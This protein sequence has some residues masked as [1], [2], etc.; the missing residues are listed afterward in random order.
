MRR[1]IFLLALLCAGAAA[2]LEPMPFKDAEEEARF[3]AL[4]AELRCVM[5]QNQSLADSNAMIAVDLRKEVLSLMQ[6]G[7]TDQQ[8]K[9]FLVERYTE[10]VLYQPRV[11]ERTM[12]LWLTPAIALVGGAVVLIV[13]VRRR[14]AQLKTRSA[15]AAEPRSEIKR[16][17]EEE[18]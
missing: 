15:S 5:C 8:I 9:D 13:V 12:A 4:V 7:K 16:S 2:A 14:A 11:N 10:F 17:D 3:R 18:W 1:W 6:S